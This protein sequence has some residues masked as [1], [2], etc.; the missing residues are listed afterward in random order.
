MFSLFVISQW[1]GK[2]LKPL[3]PDSSQ[4]GLSNGAA[5]ICIF[6]LF[7]ELLTF[8]M[9]IYQFQRDTTSPSIIT[10]INWNFW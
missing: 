4:Q 8:K 6:P 10:T 7:T 1:Y 3:V 9:H 5:P 2:I